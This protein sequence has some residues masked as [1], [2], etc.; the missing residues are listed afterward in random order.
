MPG[1]NPRLTGPDGTGVLIG[2]P[3][4]ARQLAASYA[5]QMCGGD[6]THCPAVVLT[7]PSGK[8]AVA[9]QAQAALGMWHAALPGYPISLATLDQ[10]ALLGALAGHTLQLWYI[11]W[12]ADYPDPQD[13]LTTQF[14][15]GAAYD[16]GDVNLGEATQQML[17]ADITRDPTQR[18][19]RYAAAEQ[20]L[21]TNVAWVPL[22]QPRV[23]W[24]AA[25]GVVGFKLDGRGMSTLATWQHVYLA[26]Q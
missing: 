10:T 21:V 1:Y 25:P 5:A 4:R 11:T 14:L 18:M 13:W 26:R 9:A 19:Q 20:L 2:N 22:D 16:D 3:D 17:A 23:W 15:P 12:I 6:L 8:A 7:I 24:E